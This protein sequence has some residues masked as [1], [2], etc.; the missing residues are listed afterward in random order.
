M[1]IHGEALVKVL[2]Q[3]Y[4]VIVLTKTGIWIRDA[5]HPLPR[6]AH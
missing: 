2:G 6:E 5:C 4:D 3:V 1:E